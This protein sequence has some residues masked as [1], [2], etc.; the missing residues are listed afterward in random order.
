MAESLPVRQD[1]AK[2]SE[3]FQ[4]LDVVVERGATRYEAS[5]RTF[6]P[7]YA[8]GPE[9]TEAYLHCRIFHDWLPRRVVGEIQTNGSVLG[10]V[11]PEGVGDK[12][13]GVGLSVRAKKYVGNVQPMT[14]MGIAGNI[15]SLKSSGHFALKECY[16]LVCPHACL[17]NPDGL[18]ANWRSI[19]TGER[20]G[21]LTPALT[22]GTRGTY[23]E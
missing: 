16:V 9:P 14:V 5:G 6:A 10:R 23:T 21:N 20:S 19:R 4:A 3:P 17:L 18:A 13:P 2:R 15:S 7:L 8:P 12:R 22:T 1:K 11:M